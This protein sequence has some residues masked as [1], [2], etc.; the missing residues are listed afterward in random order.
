MNKGP[1]VAN[2]RPAAFVPIKDITP[3]QST[4]AIRGRCSTKSDLRRYNRNGRAGCVFNF[5]LLDASGEVRCVCFG[6]TAEKYDQIVQQGKCYELSQ[7]T[8]KTMDASK[9]KWNQTGHSCEIT[10]EKTSKVRSRMF[11]TALKHSAH[12][13]P[14]QKVAPPQL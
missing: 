14:K 4:W 2:R 8:A 13:R 5:D 3:Y 10:L 1:T 7:A 6:E 9:R 12:M 11:G